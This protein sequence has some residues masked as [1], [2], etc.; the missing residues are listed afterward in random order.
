MAPTTRSSKPDHEKEEHNKSPIKLDN[1]ILH[2]SPKTTLPT[3]L[4]LQDSTLRIESYTTT[5][6]NK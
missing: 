1:Q 4:P 2:L 5:T 6:L 3:K